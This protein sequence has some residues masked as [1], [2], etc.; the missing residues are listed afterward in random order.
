MQECIALPHFGASVV[1]NMAYDALECVHRAGQGC[2]GCGCGDGADPN[3]RAIFLHVMADT[4]GSVA[5]IMSTL[6]VRPCRSRARDST[7]METSMSA[8]SNVR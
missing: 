3:M 6:A 8:C 5:V 1:L 4:L 7:M 2:G